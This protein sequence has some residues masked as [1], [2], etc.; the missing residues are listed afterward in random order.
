MNDEN[1]KDEASMHYREWQQEICNYITD[2]RSGNKQAFNEL[3]RHTEQYVY[4]CITKHGVPEESASDVMQKVYMAMYEN[5]ETLRDVSAAI[6]WIKSIA[7]HK[8]MDYFRSEKKEEIIAG[9]MEL[10]VDCTLEDTMR[11]PEDILENKTMQEMIRNMIDSLPKDYKQVIIAYYFDECKIDDIAEILGIPSNTVKTRLSRARK[12]LQDSIERL[13][14]EQGIRLHSVSAAPILLLLFH[15]EAEATA[16]PVGISKIV[17]AAM[18][19][20]LGQLPQLSGG[21]ISSGMVSQGVGTVGTAG[22]AEMVGAKVAGLAVKKL[23]V[24]IVASLLAGGIIIYMVNNNDETVNTTTTEQVTDT[25]TDSPLLTEDEEPPKTEK[26]TEITTTEAGSSPSTELA[27]PMQTEQ[28]TEAVTTEE[29]TTETVTVD[30]ERQTKLRRCYHDIYHRMCQTRQWADGTD[31]YISTDIMEALQ[32]AVFDFDKD[33]YE[34]FAVSVITA[35]NMAARQEK[36]YKCNPDTGEITCMLTIYPGAAYY[37]NQTAWG[38]SDNS[39]RFGKDLFKYNATS[40][41]YERQAYVFKWTRDEWGEQYED[42]LLDDVDND[43]DGIVYRFVSPDNSVSYLEQD[44][45]D[46]WYKQQIGTA[47]QMEVPWIVFSNGWQ[48]E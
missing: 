33:G 47:G 20:F 43:G 12:K 16:V 37:D 23:V 21:V 25:E 32:Y 14:K 5:L 7:Y 30:P 34:E 19:Q 17:G 15:L 18:G 29:A 44:E 28:M 41:I 46:A 24:W 10:I 48:Y 40:G 45:Y 2:I 35:D 9:Q 6:G 13:E 1:F 42:D 36:L 38:P 39:H 4:Y 8:S 11:L 31:L 22:A 27:E 3:Y 26:P